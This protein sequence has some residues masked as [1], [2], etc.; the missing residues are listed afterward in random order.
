MFASN[1]SSRGLPGWLILIAVMA[2]IGPVSI[3]LYLPAF[4]MIET[5]FGE[6]GVERTM[7]SYLIGLAVGQLLYGPISDRFGRKPP[8]YFGFIV[9][10]VG[11][12][13]CALSTSMTMLMICRIVQALGACSGLAIGRAIVRDRCEPEQAAR[14]FSTLMTIVSVAPILAPVAGGFIV[15]SFG[16]RIVFFVQAALGVGI[17][18]GMHYLLTESRD[19]K[20]V[21]PLGIGSAL[22][23]YIDLFRDRGFIG[24]SLI[25]GFAMAALFCYVSGAPTILTRTYD[26]SPEFFG[27]L[28]GCNGIAFMTASRLNMIALRKQKPATILRRFVWIPVFVGLALIG[29]AFVAGIPLA[30]VVALQ[31]CFFVT[32][33]RV[34]PNVSALA[35][36]DR[37]RDAGAASA[38]LGSLQSLAAMITGAAIAIFNNDTLLPLALLMTG[39]VALAALLH[40]WTLRGPSQH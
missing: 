24:H 28:I 30:I 5:E 39:S 38:L 31:F 21:R 8:L 34:L 12:I 37:A 35:L 2:G 4:P 18:I 10:T 26:I 27:L 13:G 15:A 20:H 33:A 17:L 7:A 1:S 16:W 22:R 29:A 14:A 25:G 19:P 32:T 9:Y 11:A 40:R 6:R 23:N 3:D 36:A